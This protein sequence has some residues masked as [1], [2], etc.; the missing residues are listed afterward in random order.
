MS[1]TL[2]M[3]VHILQLVMVTRHSANALV[4]SAQPV[5]KSALF[6][7]H[8]YICLRVCNMTCIA[9]GD[10]MVGSGSDCLIYLRYHILKSTKS[11]VD[12]YWYKCPLCRGE[13]TDNSP[14]L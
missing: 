13:C 8:T 14:F 7:R 2:V 6:S 12:T 10:V 5:C 4:F 11:C 3:C 9:E 1:W